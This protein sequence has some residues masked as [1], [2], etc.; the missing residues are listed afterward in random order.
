MRKTGRILAA[1]ALILALLLGCAAAESASETAETQAGE[2]LIVPVGEGWTL[3]M[4]EE[5]LVEILRDGTT[6]VELSVATEFNYDCEPGDYTL[7]ATVT[8]SDT[9]HYTYSCTNTCITVEAPQEMQT[10]DLGD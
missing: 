8:I 9:E 2:R 1:L 6:T 3:Y 7:N 4:D 10:G 5:T